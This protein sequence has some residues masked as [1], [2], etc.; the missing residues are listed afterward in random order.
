MLENKFN[1][2]IQNPNDGQLPSLCLESSL[3]PR[4]INIIETWNSAF[5]V[6]VGIYAQKFPVEAPAFMEYSELIR[7]LAARGHNWK[8]YG[9]N[10]CYHS[11]RAK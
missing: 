2:T 6:F 3:K 11:R 8:Y 1:I 9:E 10:L 7:D 4:R 5:R